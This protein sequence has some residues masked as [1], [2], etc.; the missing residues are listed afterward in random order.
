[1]CRVRL[2]D[3]PRFSS[4]KIYLGRLSRSISRRVSSGVRAR[5]MSLDSPPNG[6]AFPCTPPFI[7]WSMVCV[8]VLGLPGAAAFGGGAFPSA[9]SSARALWTAPSTAMADNMI[10]ACFIAP[11]LR[12]R[13]RPRQGSRLAFRPRTQ[14]KGLPWIVGR[15]PEVRSKPT[16]RAGVAP[17]VVALITRCSI[18]RSDLKRPIDPSGARHP[19]GAARPAFTN[20]SG[21]DANSGSDGDAGS[22]HTRKRGAHSATRLAV[23]HR[24]PVGQSCLYSGVGLD[25][26]SADFAPLRPNWRSRV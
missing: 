7:S 26:N 5:V 4:G 22:G 18:D 10:P 11:L 12:K 3:R 1:M 13:K 23:W 24:L 15:Q 25:R 6:I 17:P 21:G 20:T 14:G 16:T 8:G 9:L 19:T 2:A